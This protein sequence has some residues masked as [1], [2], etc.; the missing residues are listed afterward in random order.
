MRPHPGYQ[1]IQELPRGRLCVLPRSISHQAG[2][3]PSGRPF[4]RNEDPPRRLARYPASQDI[5]LRVRKGYPDFPVTLPYR[6]GRY[7]SVGLYQP[8]GSTL[9]GLSVLN[10]SNDGASR[11][12]PDGPSQ[13]T[14]PDSL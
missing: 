3:V 9:Y 1:F 6:P 12:P 5:D 14:I 2:E 4:D 11:P 8:P 13:G 10:A 7:R